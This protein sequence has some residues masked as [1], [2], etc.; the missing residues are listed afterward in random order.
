[1][2]KKP[3]WHM[4]YYILAG[5]YCAEALTDFWEDQTDQAT[6][7][8]MD[9]CPTSTGPELFLK[10]TWLLQLRSNLDSRKS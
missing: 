8:L 5:V 2:F 6:T 9:T 1:M 3:E 7:S 10:A 4:S